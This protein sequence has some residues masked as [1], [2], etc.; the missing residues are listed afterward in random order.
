MI[1]HYTMRGTAADGQGW[2]TVG[3]IDIGAGRFGQLAEIALR[4]TFDKLTQGKAI[5]GKPGVGCRGPY[6]VTDLV[7]RLEEDS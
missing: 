4:E 6:R 2:E 3:T 5:F 7:L 1:Y